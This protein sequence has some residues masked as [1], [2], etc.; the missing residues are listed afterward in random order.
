VTLLALLNNLISECIV[1][2]SQKNRPPRLCHAAPDDNLLTVSQLETHAIF[3]DGNSGN[4][5]HCS[6]NLIV[7]LKVN[8][9]ALWMLLVSVP[10]K[11]NVMVV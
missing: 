5:V 11:K 10:T 6:M 8:A 2:A 9:A 4:I 1:N 7:E 3:S